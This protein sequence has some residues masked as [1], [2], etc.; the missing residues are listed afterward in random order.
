MTG[1]IRNYV[2][3]RLDPRSGQMLMRHELQIL[4]G[5]IILRII[6]STLPYYVVL[7]GPKGIGK[8]RGEA[9]TGQESLPDNNAY[10]HSTLRTT[11][12]LIEIDDMDE[13]LLKPQLVLAMLMELS[14]LPGNRGVG[15]LPQHCEVIILGIMPAYIQ[16]S[17]VHVDLPYDLFEV[18]FTAH[19]NE[20]QAAQQHYSSMLLDMLQVTHRDPVKEDPIA[21]Q[22]WNAGIVAALESPKVTKQ[23]ASLACQGGLLP[24][25]LATV[26]IWTMAA[27]ESLVTEDLL[28]EN[29]ERISVDDQIDALWLSSD[30]LQGRRVIE[31]SK[32]EMIILI[33]IFCISNGG[34][35]AVHFDAMM[36]KFN[37]VKDMV[38]PNGMLEALGAFHPNHV[39]GCFLSLLTAGV[40]KSRLSRPKEEGH[41]P[42]Q[43]Q[44][45]YLMVDEVYLRQGIER[46]FGYKRSRAILAI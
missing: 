38:A 45:A 31:R 28:M 40:L 19:C 39:W 25:T 41:V 6:D 13:F 21:L 4:F 23:V 18:P 46:L 8:A 26:C 17:D 24:S 14:K 36:R 22:A 5:Q 1:I 35:K 44:T 29:L 10:I 2:L 12:L 15:T 30:I 37:E 7:A 16:K 20:W 33:A 11:G 42:P 3:R 32:I 9:F 43:Y 34:R 27:A